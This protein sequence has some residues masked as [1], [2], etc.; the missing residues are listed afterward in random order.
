MKK[1]VVRI[2]GAAVRWRNFLT[3]DVFFETILLRVFGGAF[4]RAEN[5]ELTSLT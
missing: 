1:Y 3:A 2:D 5:G 4:A